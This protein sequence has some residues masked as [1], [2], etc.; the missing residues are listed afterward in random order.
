M[1]AY[2][3]YS[4]SKAENNAVKIKVSQFTKNNV[5]NPIKSAYFEPMYKCVSLVYSEN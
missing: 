2:L 1:I 4:Y 5:F 3:R